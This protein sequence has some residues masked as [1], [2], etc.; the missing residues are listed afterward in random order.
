VKKILKAI[1]FNGFLI[2]YSKKQNAYVI[3]KVWPSK[4]QLV[5]LMLKNE[6]N[7]YFFQDSEVD[8]NKYPTINKLIA[9]SVELKDFHSAKKPSS[10]EKVP[11]FVKE[12]KPSAPNPNFH[13]YQSPTSSTERPLPSGWEKLLHSTSKLPYFRNQLTGIETF[14][15]PRL[16]SPLPPGYTQ[17]SDQQGNP[18]FVNSQTGVSSYD[19]PRIYFY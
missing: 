8:Y 14:D 17:L 18:Y 1:Q 4:R 12:L 3:S 11:S 6:N 9:Q 13:Q 2:R 16:L 15:D 19:N 10:T 5:H 7:Q